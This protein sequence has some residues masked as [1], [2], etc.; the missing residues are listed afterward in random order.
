MALLPDT[1][2][3]DA[4]DRF[5]WL[6]GRILADLGG[7][8]IKLDPPGT[9]RNGPAVACLQRQQAPARSRS[10]HACRSA[11][12]GGAARQGRHLPAD[13]GDIRLRRLARSARVARALPAVGGGRHHAVRE[14]RAAQRLARDRYRGDGGG[15]RDGARRRARRRA[16]AR[17]RAAILRLG[18]GAGGDRRAGGA[19]SARGHRPR[20]SGRGV[21]AGL[22]GRR[23][24]PCA[25]LLSTF[26]GSSRSAP[27]HS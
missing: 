27:A 23:H 18:R 2:I 4:T 17:E 22:R 1:L 15:R 21:G 10:G 24:R 8:V 9:D 16:V 5:G 6:A 3:V 19:P 11:R 12:A 20:R 13:A 7:D 26:S 14:R 25:G